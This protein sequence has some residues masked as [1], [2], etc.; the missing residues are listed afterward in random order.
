[1]GSELDSVSTMDAVG[2]HLVIIAI[3]ELRSSAAL[4]ETLR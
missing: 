2:P 1:M 4:L 3:T